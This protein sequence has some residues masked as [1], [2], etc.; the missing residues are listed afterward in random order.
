M[1]NRTNRFKVLEIPKDPTD[2]EDFEDVAPYNKLENGKWDSLWKRR[3]PIYYLLLDRFSL[4]YDGKLMWRELNDMKEQIEKLQKSLY[5]YRKEILPRRI[6][7][8]CLIREQ[9]KLCSEDTR[10]S[11][12]DVILLSVITSTMTDNP[13]TFLADFFHKVHDSMMMMQDIISFIPIETC[14][15]KLQKHL[16]Q[17]IGLD[18]KYKCTKNYI[19]YDCQFKENGRCSH[20]CEIERANE[21]LERDEYYEENYY[22]KIKDLEVAY[23]RALAIKE[24]RLDEYLEDLYSDF[25]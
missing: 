21:E 15:Q 1:L 9:E 16:D 7:L 17:C 12:V 13:P 24:D 6:E 10:E 25:D 23:E 11:K 22:D 14:E 19:N 20:Y 8:R 4:R 2:Y 5:E 3:H 18:G